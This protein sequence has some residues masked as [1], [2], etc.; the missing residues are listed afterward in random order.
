MLGFNGV[1]TATLIGGKVKPSLHYLAQ[2]G[3]HSL[4]FEGMVIASLPGREAK[5][6]LYDLAHFGTYSL[7]IDGEVFAVYVGE[8]RGCGRR[9]IV[10]LIH[11]ARRFR[12]TSYLISFK[13]TAHCGNH[14]VSV[15]SRL[16]GVIETQFVELKI[17]N[18]LRICFSIILMFCS[19]AYESIGLVDDECC[20]TRMCRSPT[21]LHVAFVLLL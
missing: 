15:P 8:K 1:V 3:T 19:N 6:C 12:Y 7:S 5:P 21:S 20:E 14:L 11:F 4:T 13:G 10:R 2:T 16:N 9:H 17:Y 18:L